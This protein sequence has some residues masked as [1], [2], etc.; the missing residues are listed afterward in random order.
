MNDLNLLF[1][2][3][4]YHSYI[5]EGDPENTPILLREYLESRKDI[6]ENNPDIFYQNYD[7]FTINN[8]SDIK[9]W[10]NKLGLTNKK[11][12]CIISTKFINREA[13]QALLKLIE[14]P[15]SNTHFFIIVPNSSLLADTILSRT[16]LVK[17]LNSNIAFEKLAKDF[18]NASVDSRLKMVA[19]IIEDNKNN[20]NSGGLRHQTIELMNEIEKYYF[21]LF[22]NDRNNTNTQ[23]ILNEIQKNRTYLSTPG[24]S[25]KMILEHIALVL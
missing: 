16:H 12:I 8:V 5:V 22:K 20:E 3:D 6:G 25:V 7:S 15:Q 13:E 18:I 19:E 14:E 23:F 21:N 2:R 1:P 9:D 10:H 17:I 24:A 11:R 4:L